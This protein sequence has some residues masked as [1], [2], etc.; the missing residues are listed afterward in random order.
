MDQ[1]GSIVGGERQSDYGYVLE[2]ESPAFA[3]GLVVGHER[4]EMSQE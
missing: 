1:G 4:K 3:N 2:M